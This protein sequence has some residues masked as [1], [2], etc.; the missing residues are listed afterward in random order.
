[1]PNIYCCLQSVVYAKQHMKAHKSCPICGETFSGRNTTR[2]L[3]FHLRRHAKKRGPFSCK[4]CKKP[5]PYRS[6]LK[7]HEWSCR[8]NPGK[9]R[10]PDAS[11]YFFC[12]ACTMR[13]SIM[14]APTGCAPNAVGISTV[15][16]AHATSASTSSG[17]SALSPEARFTANSVTKCF[18][19]V[20]LAC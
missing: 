12:R 4:F 11:W 20:C 3:T 6:R 7:T 2:S 19:S 13:E 10:N 15:R 16:T 8:Q 5:Y 9:K 18:Q 14:L 17:W 1:M